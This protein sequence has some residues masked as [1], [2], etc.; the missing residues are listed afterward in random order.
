MERIPFACQISEPLY[1]QLRGRIFDPDLSP[2]STVTLGTLRGAD[3]TVEVRYVRCAI[4]S[5]ETLMLLNQ[6]K[7]CQDYSNSTVAVQRD[8]AG[9]IRVGIVEE[10]FS[11][12]Q[13]EDRFKQFYSPSVI[14]WLQAIVDALPVRVI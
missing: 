14:S 10:A 3:A 8:F 4:V 9:N 12:Q 6:Y 7:L 2:H 5:I 13:R 11:A 1:K